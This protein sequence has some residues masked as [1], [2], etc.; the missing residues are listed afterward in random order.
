M[1][2]L[3]MILK[4]SGDVIEWYNGT[5]NNSESTGL[6]NTAFYDCILIYIYI[7]YIGNDF[8]ICYCDGVLKFLPD[9]KT[10]ISLRQ[11][12]S[13][14]DK[15]NIPVNTKN[16]Y[17]YKKHETRNSGKLVHKATS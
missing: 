14:V 9:I 7:I 3:L 17:L 2:L 15:L 5:T 13:N 12:L 1:S 6:Y 11:I 16:E 4:R 10:I 8:L